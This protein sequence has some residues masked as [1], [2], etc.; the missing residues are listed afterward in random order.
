LGIYF[1][2]KPNQLE[3]IESLNDGYDTLTVLYMTAGTPPT[4]H[5]KLYRVHM[6]SGMK[7]TPNCRHTMNSSDV[8]ELKTNLGR[9]RTAVMYKTVKVSYPSFNDSIVS[10]WFGFKSK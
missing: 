3:T 4:Y 6:I 5:M 7:Q 8:S 9:D 2:L 1:D 10:N